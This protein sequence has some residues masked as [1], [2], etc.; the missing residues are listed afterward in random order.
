MQDQ[1]TDFIIQRLNESKEDLKKQ[2][3]SKHPLSIARHFVVDNL[4]P[5][6]IAKKIYA[7]F[8]QQN[9]MRLLNISGELKLKYSQLKDTSSLLQ[10]FH[11]A[12]Q[13][14]RVISIIEEI[15][16]IRN[17]LPD[18]SRLAGGV[19]RLLKGHFINPHIDH[20]HD[21]D[22]K[23]YRVVNMLYYV[24]PEWKIENGGNFELW[25]TAIE[26]KLVIPSFFNRL[27]VM[28]TNRTSWHSV[29]P[30]VSDASR[31]CIFNYYFSKESPEDEEYFHGA[32][33]V[34]FN[35]LIRP[36]PEQKIRRVFSKV[37]SRLLGKS[38]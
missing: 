1:F 21:I 30:V 16:E 3:F 34:F 2:F 31:C 22:K 23:Y 14:Q 37:K 29:N 6:E 18:T 24:S 20:S 13:S 9:K 19:S 28:A 4:L 8:P 27:L 7:E 33:S 26:K 5:M 12:I 11:Y 25:D 38:W 36:R 10:D 32:P 17:Q 15:T 35:P